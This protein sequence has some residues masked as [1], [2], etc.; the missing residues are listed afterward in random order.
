MDGFERSVIKNK[1]LNNK[2]GLIDLLRDK[3]NEPEN[4]L[5]GKHNLQNFQILDVNIKQPPSIISSS[6]LRINVS[7]FQSC[8]IQKCLADEEHRISL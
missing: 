8:D 1:E 7:P 3:M 4:E 2:I 5:K 6:L